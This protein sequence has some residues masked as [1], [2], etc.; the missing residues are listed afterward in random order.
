MEGNFKFKENK[1]MINLPF[2]KEE[3]GKAMINVS[4]YSKFQVVY[5]FLLF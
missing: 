3:T 1:Y 5:T 4:T 2:E